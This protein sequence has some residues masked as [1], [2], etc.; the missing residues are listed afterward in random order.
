MPKVHWYYITLLIILLT[1]PIAVF[2]SGT[3]QQLE[4]QAATDDIVVH[5]VSSTQFP[6]PPGDTFTARLRVD[7]NISAN[8]DDGAYDVTMATLDLT[9]DDA[10]LEV[11]S[12]YPTSPYAKF[13]TSS[14]VPM[15]LWTISRQSGN[16][17]IATVQLRALTAGTGTLRVDPARSVVR[18]SLNNVPVDSIAVTVGQLLEYSIEVGATPNS[19]TNTPPPAGPT[20]TPTITPTPT[21]TPIPIP[22]CDLCGYCFS[23]AQ[24]NTPPP[25]NYDDCIACLYEYP[26][27]PTDVLNPPLNPIEENYWSVLG[28]VNT[29]VGSFTNQAVLAA[30]GS[31]GGV[32]FLLLLYGGFLVLTAAGSASKL[33]KGKR[34]I[35]TAVASL[36]VVLFA[37]AIMSFIGGNMLS[38]P[39]F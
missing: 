22:E 15:S 39:G 16:F 8:P 26:G 13:H 5:V 9:L 30:T 11:V 35:Y 18:G 25:P 17:E 23:D 1:L 24:S 7:S 6:V 2:F 37:A 12:I 36:L 21:P 10:L 32:S 34:I 33:L 38:I 29:A 3:P 27:D 28:C 20:A 14:P 19:P 31:I 4:K